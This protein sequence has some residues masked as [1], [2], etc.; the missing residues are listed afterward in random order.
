MKHYVSCTDR[1]KIMGWI[2][3]PTAV[4]VES[5]LINAQ[6]LRDEAK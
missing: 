4:A 3:N 1:D 5:R 6:D 2:A